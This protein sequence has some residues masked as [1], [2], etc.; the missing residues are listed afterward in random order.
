MRFRLENLPKL[1][2]PLAVALLVGVV[3]VQELSLS[4][5]WAIP[6]G[7]WCGLQVQYRMNARLER[8]AAAR[9]F[10]HPPRGRARYAVG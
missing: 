3:L 2:L 6:A 5:A 4:R 10:R 9:A 7:L 1:A 8:E